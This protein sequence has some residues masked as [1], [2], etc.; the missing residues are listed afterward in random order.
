MAK[1][2]VPYKLKGGFVGTLHMIVDTPSGY[3]AKAI[4]QGMIDANGGEV[5]GTPK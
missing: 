2:N 1:Y 4:V 5:I 3:V